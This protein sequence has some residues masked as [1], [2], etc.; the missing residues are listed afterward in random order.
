[1]PDREWVRSE[2]RAENP[3]IRKEEDELGLDSWIQ[4]RSTGWDERKWVWRECS[5]TREGLDCTVEVYMSEE[6]VTVL[7]VGTQQEWHLQECELPRALNL[8]R[9]S[10]EHL[11]WNH[12]EQ[13]QHCTDLPCQVTFPAHTEQEKMGLWLG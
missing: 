7:R 5:I 9:E 13:V 4:I 11:R 8:E 12:L 2:P 10:C 6:G 3:G 1:M